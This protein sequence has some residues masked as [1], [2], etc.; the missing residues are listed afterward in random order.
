M[1][2]ILSF[3]NDEE[4]L[5]AILDTDK[6]IIHLIKHGNEIDI[7]SPSIEP[8]EKEKDNYLYKYGNDFII[9]G[10]VDGILWLSVGADLYHKVDNIK[11]VSNIGSTDALEELKNRYKNIKFIMI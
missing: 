4:L 1:S 11:I 9:N 8:L 5:V 10:Y 3:S 2:N 7:S 6:D